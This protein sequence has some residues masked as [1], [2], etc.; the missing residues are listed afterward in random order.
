MLSVSLTLLHLCA[1]LC[2]SLA[3]TLSMLLWD[4]S[5]DKNIWFVKH[6]VQILGYFQNKILQHERP[7]QCYSCYFIVIG[8][9]DFYYLYVKISYLCEWSGS[10]GGLFNQ[11]MAK[12]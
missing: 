8:D 9:P 11:Q 4:S 7:I 2:T 12:S 5:T 3:I 1:P 6:A 10:L